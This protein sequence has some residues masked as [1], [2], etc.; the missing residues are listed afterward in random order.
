[1]DALRIV[2][3]HSSQSGVMIKLKLSHGAVRGF[4][5][6]FA[7]MRKVSRSHPYETTVLSSTVSSSNN[8][9]TPLNASATFTGASEE[10]IP[11]TSVVVAC[12]TDQ[13][14]TLYVDFSTDSTNW[15]STLSF[16]VAANVNEVHRIT[17]TRKFFRVRF[18]NTSSSNQTFIR[19]QTLL[20]SYQ[21]LTSS[22][23]S[24]IQQDADTLVVRPLDFNLNL[25]NNLLQGHNVTI[26]D[27]FNTD[28]DTA[29]V[30]EDL[31]TSGGTYTGFVTAAAAGE[32]VVAGAD[33]GTVYYS[34]M[35]T[36]TDTDYTFGSIAVTGA[37]TYALGHDIW[38][39]NFA[40]FD[41]GSTINVGLITLRHTATPANIFWTIEANFGQSYC[42][43]YS[44]PVGNK[45]FIDRIT[46]N[47]RGST[48]GSADGFFYY[49][50][51]N[52]SPRLRFPF[53][54]QFGTLYFDD[55]DYLITIPEQVD[56]IPRVTFAS[57]NNLSVKTSYRLIKVKQ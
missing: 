56:I 57:A 45:I 11:Y 32:I 27:G 1:V 43:A 28:V 52:E 14:G 55:A 12:K 51:W 17:V 13:N 38:R 36:A 22:L 21:S 48:S 49:K 24:S 20:G 9:T 53:E 47:L 35:A 33:T 18:T 40:Y 23:N 39:S 54:L 37:G 46:A 34:Y 3:L 8:T 4:F 19:L 5:C 31:W 25:A 16:S 2:C 7:G 15:D 44:V 26:K 29:S 10:A 50:P 42:A 6:I 30:P 41:N